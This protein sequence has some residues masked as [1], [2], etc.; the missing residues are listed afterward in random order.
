[1]AINISDNI[2]SHP[3]IIFLGAI[4]T[5]FVSGIGAYQTI[6]KMADLE[7]IQRR[8]SCD[9]KRVT[10]RVITE[11]QD[12]RIAFVDSKDK[13]YQ[14]MC[15]QPGR[16]LLSIN[17]DGYVSEERVL[18]I[19]EADNIV[20]VNLKKMTRPMTKISSKTKYTGE[21]ISL[22]FQ[23]LPVRAAFQIIADFTGKNMIV[24]D[25]VQGN[26]TLRLKNIPWDEV[27]DM[28]IAIKGLKKQDSGNVILISDR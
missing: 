6:L 22:N 11:P 25:A 2:K 16:Y 21:K 18:Q 3:A 20:L 19:N 8:S 1:M 7:V 9:E 5:G 27:M 4:I 28:I 14:L 13:F 26:I 24:D 12:A 15:I 17:A 10:L 23:N